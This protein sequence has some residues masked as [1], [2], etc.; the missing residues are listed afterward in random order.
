MMKTFC[1]LLLLAVPVNG[2]YFDE[3]GA[4]QRPV[5]KVIDLLKAMTT[6]LEEDQ[7]RDQE[8][9][10]AMDCWCKKNNADKK[11]AI[12]EGKEMVEVLTARMNENAALA[13][14]LQPQIRQ[15]TKELNG[16]QHTLEKAFAIRQ[17]QIKSFQEDEQSLLDS[18]SGVAAAKEALTGKS[19]AQLSKMSTNVLMSMA[20]RLQKVMDSQASRLV[21]VLSRADRENLASFIK[22]L[23]SGANGKSFLQNAAANSLT[24]PSDS[25]VGIL[26]AMADDFAADLNQEL[27]EEKENKK[28]YQE[29]KTAKENEVKTLQKTITD[30]KQ[31]KSTAEQVAATS[32]KDLAITKKTLEEDIAFQAQVEKKC[33]QGDGDFDERKAARQEEMAAVS[34]TLEVLTSDEAR[35]QL[36]RN[37]ISFLQESSESNLRSRVAELLEKAAKKSNNAALVTLAMAAKLDS[38]TKVKK[39]IEDMTSALKKQQADEVAQNDLCIADLNKN[40]LDTE[41]KTRAKGALEAKIAGLQTDI[42]TASAEITAVSDE[43]AELQK[44]LQIAGETRQKENTEFQGGVEEQ[45]STQVL[46]KKALKVLR[47]FYGSTESFVQ[48]SQEPAT[49]GPALDALGAPEGFSEYKKGSGGLGA[50]SLLEQIINDSLKI[51]AEL[52]KAEQDATSAYEAFIAETHASLKTKNAQLESKKKEKADFAG[53]LSEA[54]QGLVS[55]MDELGALSETKMDLHKECDYVMLNFE[56]RQKARSEEV[57]ALQQAKG[58]LSGSSLGA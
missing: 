53:D 21:N 8:L 23:H 33:N 25:I 58:I 32:K 38:F 55:T 30:K 34:K 54:R 22:T 20:K 15:H 7:T 45:K 18:I 37:S 6:K 16:A 10:D 40:Q 50:V 17:S 31:Q 51:E 9:K 28:A 36:S 44:Q 5:N 3:D 49:E 26:V 52:T 1:V 27:A 24:A 29:L 35:D 2:L 14:S 42:K 56:V 57:E 12:A 39:S 48:I 41:D 19:F 46:L 13:E 47:D 43:I 4:K 11:K